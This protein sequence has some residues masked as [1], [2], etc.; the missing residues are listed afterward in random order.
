[1]RR[2]GLEWENGP[3]VSVNENSSDSHYEP[4]A[5]ACRAIQEG[6]FMLVDI[7][8]RRTVPSLLV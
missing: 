7:W 3:N 1:M 5:G 4:T 2:N 6:D 8:A